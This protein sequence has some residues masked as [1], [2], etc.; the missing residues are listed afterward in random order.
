MDVELKRAHSERLHR[1]RV[2]R[3]FC[4]GK[5]IIPV[6]LVVGA[7]ATEIITHHA[8]HY[9]CTPSGLGVLRRGHLNFNSAA[10]YELRPESVSES[11]VPIGHNRVRQQSMEPEN[12]AE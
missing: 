5:E 11:R 9:F 3:R 2:V 8:I 10:V 7:I 4:G 1:G 12:V 6:G